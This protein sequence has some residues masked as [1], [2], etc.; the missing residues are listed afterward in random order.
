MFISHFIK[1]AQD[2]GHRKKTQAILALNCYLLFL[3]PK[4]SVT[5]F[6]ISNFLQITNAKLTDWTRPK[7]TTQASEQACIANILDQNNTPINEK[8]RNLIYALLR[9]HTRERHTNRSYGKTETSI[10]GFT[11]ERKLYALSILMIIKHV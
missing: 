11:L 5:F 2:H 4:P 9:S 7:S 6:L 8:I 10:E 3:Q 1:Q